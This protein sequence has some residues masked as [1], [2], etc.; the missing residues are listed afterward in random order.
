M[1]GP[2]GIGVGVLDRFPKL[3]FVDGR[4]TCASQPIVEHPK[5][6]GSSKRKIPNDNARRLYP[7]D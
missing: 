7:L 6:S 3:R 4:F 5:L 2:L 1:A